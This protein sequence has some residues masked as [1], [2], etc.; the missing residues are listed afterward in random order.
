MNHWACKYIG[1]PYRVGGRD[2]DGVDC[3]GLLYLVY[4]DEFNIHLPL[5]PG[6]DLMAKARDMARGEYE[7][8][9]EVSAPQEGCAVAMSQ[10][11]LLHHVGIWVQGKIIHSWE[12]LR[13][14]ADTPRTLR[15]I[16]GIQIFRYFVYGLHH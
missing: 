12:N 11:E 6:E 13:V 1:L 16:R 7:G 15:Q 8:W 3:W 2:F 9:R 14:I 10:K 4:R 5:M